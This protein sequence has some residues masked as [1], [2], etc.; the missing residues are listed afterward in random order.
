MTCMRIYGENAEMQPVAGEFVVRKVRRDTVL[1][2]VPFFFIIICLVIVLH[3]NRRRT[4][5]VFRLYC[6]CEE[7]II[8][9]ALC[10]AFLMSYTGIFHAYR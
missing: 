8:L 2:A 4:C 7:K 1:L 3:F 6:T 9:I 10:V 5:T